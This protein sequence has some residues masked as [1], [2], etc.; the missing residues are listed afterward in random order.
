MDKLNLYHELEQLL[1]KNSRYCMDDGRLLKNRIVEDALSIQPLL[2]KELLGNEK[3]KKVFF[4]DV[5]GV[6]VFDKIKFQR[7]VSDTQF[8]G[9]SYTMF[10]NKIGLANENGRFVSE[11]REVVLSWPYKDCMLEGGQ[12]KEDAKRNEVFWNETLAPDEVNRLT[13]PKVFSNF[14]RYDKEGEHQV[15]HLSDNDNLI[16]KGNNLLALHS[17]K[18]KYAGQVKLIYI[19]PPY[20]FRK[21]LST[22][23]FKYNSNFHLSTWLTFMR[24]R[25]ECA[26]HL[27]APSGTI[28]IHMGDEG[29]HYLKLVADQVFGINHFI[30]TLP[31]R[32]R[33]GKSDV[34]FNFSQD[35]DWLLVYTNVEESQA[36][37]GRAVERKYY[38][39]EDYPGKPWRLADLTK[40]TTA[41]ERENSFFTMV[42]PKTGKEY[43]PSE[44]RTWCITKETF[45]FHY[46]RGYIVFP[47]DYDF[48]KITKP[49]SRKFKYE[50]EANGKL[51]S[52]ISDCQIQQFLK[53]LLYDC[54][55]EI[56]NN[57]INDLFGRDEFDYAKPENLIKIIM[58][59]VTNEGD[60]VMDFFSGSGT[61]VAVAHKLG[62]KYIGC[63]QIDHQIE[64]TVN[65]LNEVICGEQGG[66]SKSIGWQGGGSFVYCELSKANG[67]FADEIENA[68]VTGQLMDIWNR[69]KATD[70]LNYKVDVKEVDANVA[71][72]E[73]LNLDDQKR[74]L[75]E[76]LD[77][78]LLYVPLSDIDSNEYGVT[79]EDK[80]LTREFYHKN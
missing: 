48:L 41:K 54:K 17:L 76:C 15:D 45:D 9:G 44:K 21:K 8:L 14:K 69:M 20:Y 18:K 80:R 57:E 74:F 38:T 42:D 19:D 33:N 79:D 71:D 4:T 32:T 28:W 5:E 59:A 66:V 25:L 31:R 55:N 51:S 40:Q 22:D 12:T 24:D 77:K 64:L 70:Y 23:T 49:Y 53:S 67:K 34:P 47:D 78:N 13:E 27:L 58:E 46:K 36:V 26:K 56:G 2:V 52:I 29:M 10:K 60:L 16:I 43:P 3:M 68:E 73:G 50:D 65:R 75:I 30:G 7:F 63:E 37:M 11:S 6:M 62:R 61:T 1:R 72:F 35:F 39:T